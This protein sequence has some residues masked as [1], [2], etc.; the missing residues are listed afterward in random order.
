MRLSNVDI[1]KMVAECFSR[2]LLNEISVQDAYGRFY[3]KTIPQD[4]WNTFMSGVDKMT[5]FHK[6]VADI[7]AK[8]MSSRDVTKSEEI[9]KY[10]AA[11]WNK[12]PIVQQY[13]VNAV[14]EDFPDCKDEM[15]WQFLFHIVKKSR[16]NDKERYTEEEFL[17]GGLVKLYDDEELLV[18]CTLSYTASHKYYHDSHWCTASGTDGE[19]DGYKMFCNYTGMYI[20]LQFVDKR[21]RERSFQL[22][23]GGWNETYNGPD[24]D[25]ICNFDDEPMDIRG[26]YRAFGEDKVNNILHSIDIEKLKKLTTDYRN[27]ERKYYELKTHTFNKKIRKIEFAKMTSKEFMQSLEHHMNREIAREGHSYAQLPFC[28]YA[29]EQR[30]GNHF[31]YNLCFTD[32]DD[33]NDPFNIFNDNDKRYLSR[34]SH[35]HTSMAYAVAI[36]EKGEGSKYVVK[37]VFPMCYHSSGRESISL[38]SGY[39]MNTGKD[40]TVY[41]VDI[42]TGQLLAKF[43]SAFT[44]TADTYGGYF[45][46]GKQFYECELV[47]STKDTEDEQGE[48]RHIIAYLTP[49]GQLVKCDMVFRKNYGSRGWTQLGT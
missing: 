5:P 9:A 40:E 18:T 21:N 11:A 38:L 31:L 44:I 19:W 27:A 46:F 22:Q 16:A 47:L 39:D 34:L 3:A 7:I 20:L 4:I 15:I 37:T 10:A 29:L 32:G 12:G 24:L 14:K 13:L 1:R 43:P 42:S 41:A 28:S 17:D 49:T 23:Y 30:E 8:L 45:D 48:R 2:I 33:S 6:R 25:Q 35:Y 36:L 26:V